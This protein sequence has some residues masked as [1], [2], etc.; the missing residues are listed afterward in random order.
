MIKV[1]IFLTRRAD[2]T[3]EDFGTYWTEKHTPPLADQP[4]GRSRWPLRRPGPGSSP[5]LI[6]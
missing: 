5:R 1:S 2:L 4:P 6:G 3:R